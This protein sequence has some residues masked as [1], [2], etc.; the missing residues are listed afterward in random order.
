MPHPDHDPL[1]YAH[2][3]EQQ[4]Q[5]EKQL[6]PEAKYP[7]N[8]INLQLDNDVDNNICYKKNL[9]QVN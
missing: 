8:Y 1:N 7:D 5:D 9:T 4:Q 6:A 3:C 2:I